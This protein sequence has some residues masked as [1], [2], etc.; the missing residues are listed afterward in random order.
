MSCF[1][2]FAHYLQS[3]PEVVPGARR[4]DIDAYAVLYGFTSDCESIT[5]QNTNAPLQARA[6]KAGAAPRFGQV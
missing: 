2:Q 6:G 5:G 3:T 4:T 1:Q